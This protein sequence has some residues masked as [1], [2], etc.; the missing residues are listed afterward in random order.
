MEI[1]LAQSIYVWEISVGLAEG[2]KLYKEKKKKN[3][4]K[5]KR[6]EEREREKKEDKEEKCKDLKNLL[7]R[8]DY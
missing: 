4:K 3:G 8:G 6:E 7:W 2:K 5:R 1:V